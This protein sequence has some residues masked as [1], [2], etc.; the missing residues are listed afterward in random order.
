MGASIKYTGLMPSDIGKAAWN[1]IV[2]LAFFKVGEFWH[3]HFRAKHF[4]HAGAREYGYQK[5]K[6][7]ELPR[8]SKKFWRTYTGIKLRKHGHTFPLVFSGTSRTLTD[9]MVVKNTSKGASV[10]LGR[11]RALNFRPKG[12]RINMVDEMTRIS[13]AEGA[14]LVE[15]LA[16]EIQEGIDKYRRVRV[17]TL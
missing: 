16:E 14:V 5:R 11:A 10:K 12:G 2:K 9:I 15:V 4:T 1:K 6:G 3:K 17:V 7:E 8:G 13:P